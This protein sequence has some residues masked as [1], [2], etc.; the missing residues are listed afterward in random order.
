MS[1]TG[2][3]LAFPTPFLI[4]GPAGILSQLKGLGFQTFDKW[5]DESYDTISDYKE[6]FDAIENLIKSLSDLSQGKKVRIWNEM[7]PVFLHNRMVMKKLNDADTDKI[8]FVLPNFFNN[9]NYSEFEYYMMDEFKIGNFC[10]F[11]E[12]L[13]DGGGTTF[14]YH[15]ITGHEVTKRIKDKGSVLE[16]C[17][18]PGFIGYTLKVNGKAGSLVLSDIN[19]EV[20]PFIEKTNRYNG[21]DDVVYINSDVFESIPTDY[22]FDTIVSNPP[23]FKTERPDGYRNENERLISLDL[24][25][26][27]HKR[28]FEKAHMYLKPN[29]KIVLIENCDGVTENDIRKMVDGK[30]GIEYVEY[31]SYNWTGKSTFYTIILYLLGNNKIL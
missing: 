2:R 5:W 7:M 9:L 1:K 23:H 3:A 17:S 11:Y 4:Y 6:R 30:Y 21:S 24:N 22:K 26:E 13:L 27:F 10:V 29:G 25:M 19:N 14:G 16:M 20:L 28:F 8:N 31:N 15:A 12:P 18:G